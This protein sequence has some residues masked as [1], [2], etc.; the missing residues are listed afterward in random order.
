M[1]GVNQRLK[2]GELKVSM[3]AIFQLIFEFGEEKEEENLQGLW[4]KEAEVCRKPG[5]TI[6][7][8]VNRMKR[9][10]LWVLARNMHIAFVKA[11]FFSFCLYPHPLPLLSSQHPVFG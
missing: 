10:L 11:F 8:N 2:C 3:W 9:R 4:I 7:Q 5:I 6:D 1:K